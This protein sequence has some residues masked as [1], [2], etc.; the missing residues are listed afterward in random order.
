M[1]VLQVGASDDGRVDL[2][3]L[4]TVLGEQQCSEVLFE[5]GATLAGALVEQRLFDEL[6]IYMAPTL[7][8]NDARSLLNVAEIAKME[9]LLQLRIADVRLI[10]HDMR[11]TVVRKL[12]HMSE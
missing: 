7:M 4:L 8:G 11:V 12:S 9:D 6:V 3:E 2:K 5:C 1:P 10:G